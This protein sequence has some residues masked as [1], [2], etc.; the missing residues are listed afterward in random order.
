MSETRIHRDRRSSHDQHS[1]LRVWYSQPRQQTVGPGP[2]RRCTLGR[3]TGLI[4][5]PALPKGSPENGQPSFRTC[6]TTSTNRT[7]DPN[8]AEGPLNPQTAQHVYSSSSSPGLQFIRTF[9]IDV[10]DHV[11][12]ISQFKTTVPSGCQRIL[13]LRLTC[14]FLGVTLLFQPFRSRFSLYPSSLHSGKSPTL[15]HCL[16]LTHSAFSLHRRAPSH[17]PANRIARPL[18]LRSMA[19]ASA[20][21]LS[22]LLTSP[23]SDFFTL[24][25]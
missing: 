15:L 18:T 22:P 17:R 12:F 13:F 19:R 3:P 11:N 8:P 10:I 4:G 5:S 23:D 1:Y 2:A 14:C 7:L 21:G 9:S 6:I 25:R 16:I 20:F 24:L